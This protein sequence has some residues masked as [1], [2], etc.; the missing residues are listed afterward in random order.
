MQIQQ[1]G[2]TKRN[3]YQKARKRGRTDWLEE[4]REELIKYTENNT[5]NLYGAGTL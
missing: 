3:K 1:I 2:E 5:E 4:N